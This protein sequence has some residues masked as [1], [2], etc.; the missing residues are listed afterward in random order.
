MVVFI[1]GPMTDIPD[2][3]ERFEKAEKKLKSAGYTVLNP[4]KFN[5]G[6]DYKAL[7]KERILSHDIHLLSTAD[8]IY[9]LDGWENAIGCNREYGFAIGKNMPVIF[10]STYLKIFDK[11]STVEG[12][13]K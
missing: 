8:A 3:K 12:F 7:G 6:L 10:E 11:L 13:N 4:A 9:M 2:Y 5:E 1:S